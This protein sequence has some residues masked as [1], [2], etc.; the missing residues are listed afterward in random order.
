MARYVY[1]DS[2]R[3]SFTHARVAQTGVLL[4]SSCILDFAG[5]QVSPNS[6]LSIAGEGATDEN[7]EHAFVYSVGSWENGQL[8]NSASFEF[9]RLPIRPGSM[10]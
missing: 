8:A 5:R 9:L 10:I 1:P 4:V 3:M 6:T 7:G 2:S